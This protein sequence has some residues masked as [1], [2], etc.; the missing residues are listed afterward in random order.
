VKREILPQRKA[1]YESQINERIGRLKQMI[2][3]GMPV[4]RSDYEVALLEYEKAQRAWRE[5]RPEEPS[6]ALPTNASTILVDTIMKNPTNPF[7][8]TPTELADKPRKSQHTYTT[9]YISSFHKSKLT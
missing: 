7:D 9:V 1:Y 8:Q 2:I 6:G 5:S 4:A 3:E